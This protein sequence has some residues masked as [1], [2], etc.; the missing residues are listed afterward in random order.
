MRLYRA[1]G[2]QTQDLLSVQLQFLFISEIIGD[3]RLIAALAVTLPTR[4]IW[5][6]ASIYHLLLEVKRLVGRGYRP[7]CLRSRASCEP[8]VRS[9]FGHKKTSCAQP[10]LQRLAEP[11]RAMQCSTRSVDDGQCIH[12]PP[13]GSG[14]HFLRVTIS[15]ISGFFAHERAHLLLIDGELPLSLRSP[16]D[17]L[18]A[19]QR[20]LLV[21]IGTWQPWHRGGTCVG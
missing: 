20:Q 8:S 6:P 12:G 15:G 10:H 2:T 5:F 16:L 3:L 13:A 7:A 9:G 18:G 11:G 14:L 4:S 21:F 19:A 1:L 17:Y